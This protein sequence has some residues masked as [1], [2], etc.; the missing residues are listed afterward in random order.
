MVDNQSAKVQLFSQILLIGGMF[1]ANSK[2]ESKIMWKNFG[3]YHISFYICIWK[4]NVELSNKLRM[5]T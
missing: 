3:T 5:V 1:F 4:D 2:L